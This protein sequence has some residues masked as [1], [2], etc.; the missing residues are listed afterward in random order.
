[1][2]TPPAYAGAF[3]SHVTVRPLGPADV[4]RF[5]EACAALGVKPIVIEL[6][7]GAERLQPMTCSFHRG[8]LGDARRQ[9]GELAAA[10][11]ARGF[12]AARVKIEA[13]PDN[14]D[15]P[16]TDEQ[17]ADLPPENYFEYHL[18]L[19]L[20]AAAA[21]DQVRP[22]CAAH[23]A[24]LSANAFKRHVDGRFE[25]FVTLRCPGVGR[26]SA[27]VQVAALRQ[28]LAATGYEMTKT[29]CEYRVYD[30]NAGL[31]ADWVED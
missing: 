20:P 27:D 3:E 23:N 9:T 26:T 29:I 2:K 19:L 1:M 30:T 18:K 6:D 10:L 12:P 31:D 14:A 15:V 24:H 13:A 8:T 7:R 28:A 22:V 17:A 5:R 11:T 21:A 4:S 25:Q 16:K